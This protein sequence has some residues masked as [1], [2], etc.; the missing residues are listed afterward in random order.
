[1]KE[2][3]ATETHRVESWSFVL[4]FTWMELFQVNHIDLIT[5]PLLRFSYDQVPEV[6]KELDPWFLFAENQENWLTKFNLI[7]DF[8][9]DLVIFCQHKA[10]FIMWDLQGTKHLYLR[11]KLFAFFST[12]LFNNT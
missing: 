9:M 1:M 3:T 6:V 4:K 11:T 8:L 10:P 2:R 5:I 7:W 12:L